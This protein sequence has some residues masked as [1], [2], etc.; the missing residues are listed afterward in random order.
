MKTIA[1]TVLR[2][3]SD[4]A[5]KLW[6]GIREWSGDAAY[7]RYLKAQMHSPSEPQLASREQ[8][9]LEQLHKRYSRPSRCC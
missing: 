3:L 9:Y 5:T 8:F 2:R 1:I 6:R 4:A 7:E